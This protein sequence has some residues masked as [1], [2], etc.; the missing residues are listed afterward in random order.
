[1]RKGL[2]FPSKT[3]RQI[4]GVG[5]EAEKRRSSKF[6][7]YFKKGQRRKKK[8]GSLTGPSTD[9]ETEKGC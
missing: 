3:V 7:R 8:K 4:L 6:G 2:T 1:L 9:R 5:C